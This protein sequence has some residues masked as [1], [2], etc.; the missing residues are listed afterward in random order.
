MFS[1]KSQ[2]SG[3]SLRRSPTR[4]VALLLFFGLLGGR[5]ETFRIATY[6]VE[7]YLDHP[8]GTRHV[9]TPEAKHQVCENILALKPDV[10]ALEEMGGESALT[11]LRGALATNG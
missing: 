4:A 7:N 5:S 11:E 2:N 10:L 3:R 6:N 9:K 8:A 1:F